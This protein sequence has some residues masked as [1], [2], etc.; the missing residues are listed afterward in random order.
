MT[1]IIGIVGI[2]FEHADLYTRSRFAFSDTQKIDLFSAVLD[3]GCRECVILST[4]NRSDV[5]YVASPGFSETVKACLQQSSGSDDADCC[6]Y[7]LEGDDA[8]LH[9]FRVVS[10]LESAVIGEDQILGQAARAL[11][12][13]E[14]AG[15][16]GKILSRFFQSAVSTAKLIKTRTGISGI[17]LSTGYIAIKKL[18]EQLGKLDGKKIMIIGGGEMGRLVLRY[19]SEY[20]SVKVY[21]CTRSLGGT[22]HEDSGAEI[23]PFSARY[24]YIPQMD[25]VISATSS[26]HTVLNAAFI[27]KRSKPLCIVDMAMP[28]D[29]DE[30][31]Y[32]LDN[33]KVINIDDLRGEA[34][35]NL[36]RRKQLSEKADESIEEGLND[37]RAWLFHSRV[38]PAIESLNRR[39]DVIAQEVEDYL[40]SKMELSTKDKKLLDKMLRAGLHRLIR[41]PVLRLKALDSEQRQDEYVRIIKELFE[42]NNE[43]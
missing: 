14:I 19:L 7:C 35:E 11:E 22:Q 15:A 31:V 36:E 10:G 20:P 13:A 39:C 30:N 33:I 8:Q 9:L 3:A 1:D 41:E 21:I 34:Q 27:Q 6:F 42:V 25:A 26:P 40:F 2:D 4:C 18:T 24:S 5:Y 37:F 32:E 28:P 38:D 16:A 17:P 12:F 29:V 43:D 23:I